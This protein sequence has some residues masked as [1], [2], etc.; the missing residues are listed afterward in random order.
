MSKTQNCISVL[1]PEALYCRIGLRAHYAW[2]TRTT[3]HHIDFSRN[4][5]AMSQIMRECY[6]YTKVHDCI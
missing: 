5:S 4:N 3:D 2:Q 1:M 6:V